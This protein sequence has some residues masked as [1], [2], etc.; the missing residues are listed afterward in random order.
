MVDF[1][2]WDMPVQYKSILDE[3]RAVRQ[4]AGLFD[5]SH[6]GPSFLTLNAPSGD[7]DADHAA[8]SALIEPLISG[9]IAGLKPGQLRYTVLLNPAGG[10][11]DDLMV[12]RPRL[13]AGNHHEGRA[14][15]GG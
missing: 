6:M 12:G 4:R 1:A 7:P 10:M 9:D 13:P 2:G 14:S 8:V 3:H 11:I 5:V 15:A